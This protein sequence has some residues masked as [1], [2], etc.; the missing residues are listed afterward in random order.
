[1]LTRPVVRC[2]VLTLRQFTTIGTSPLA[3]RK[4][5]LVLAIELA[6]QIALFFLAAFQV[7]WLREI[8]QDHL[9]EVPERVHGGAGV[10]YEIGLA[11]IT[12][13]VPAWGLSGWV[14]LRSEGSWL[15]LPFLMGSGGLV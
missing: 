6:L 12:G 11:L 14:A 15:V 10:G 3:R 13:L 7:I 8:V 5:L 4:R 2:Q 1:L 9:N